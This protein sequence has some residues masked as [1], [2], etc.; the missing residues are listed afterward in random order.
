MYIILKVYYVR[1]IIYLLI[2][3]KFIHIVVKSDLIENVFV[4]FDKK[5]ISLDF[6]I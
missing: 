3:H 5:Q 1:D 6:F 2:N 4:S